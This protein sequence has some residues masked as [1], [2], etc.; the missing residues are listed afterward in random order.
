MINPDKVLVIDASSF[1][2]NK[3]QDF[4]FFEKYNHKIVSGFPKNHEVNEF[5]E[6]LTHVLTVEN[7]YNFYLVKACKDRG[8]KI[9]C[10]TNYEFC[11]NLNSP[12]LPV[13]QFLM[14]SY[15]HLEDMKKAYGAVYLPPPINPDEFDVPYKHN[16]LRTGKR[17]FLHI[18]GTLAAGDRNGTQD[19]LNAVKKTKSDYELVIHTQ[20]QLP[21][22]YYIQDS[23]IVYR[24]SDFPENFRIYNDFDALILPRRYGG[25][26]L[27][28]NEALMS[29]IPVLM[30][31]ISPNKELLPKKWLYPASVSGFIQA[32][33]RIPSY[34]SDI[35][36]LA[37]VID[38]FENNMEQK[39]EARDIAITNFADFNLKKEYQKLWN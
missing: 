7:P 4:T 14:P 21:E 28:T 25:L 12:H 35:V 10:Q 24:K 39:L 27:T 13:P 33:A 36:Y 16:I 15:W 18:V 17:R 2:K 19:L 34:S 9:Y 23:R 5:I 8:I 3:E 22:D 32:R 6:G 31:D 26:S 1:S 29:A 11:E 38:R 30:P 20:H 37:K